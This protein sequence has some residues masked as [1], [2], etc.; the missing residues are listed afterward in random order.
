MAKQQQ[1]TLTITDD[2]GN[3]AE[4]MLSLTSYSAAD[5]TQRAV[6]ALVVC[7][8]GAGVAVFIPIAHFFLVPALLV[9][10]PVLFYNRYRQAE[11]LEKVDG[12]CPRCGEQVTIAMESND[13]LPKWTYCP[14]CDGA[15]ELREQAEQGAQDA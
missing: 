14:A 3:A 7:L 4:G 11:A 5:R 8:G 1:R 15:V 2:K 6:V 10:G 12:T 9:A 13:K